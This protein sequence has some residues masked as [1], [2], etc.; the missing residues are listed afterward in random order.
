MTRGLAGIVIIS[1]LAVVILG[2]I[3]LHA[4]SPL[5]Y[6]PS[7][8][9]STPAHTNPAGLEKIGNNQAERL[10]PL[11]SDLLDSPGTVMVN[12]RYG[13]LD[14]AQRDLEEFAETARSFDTLVVNLEMSDSEIEE[15]RRMNRK[16]L[17]IMTELLNSTSRMNELST[18]EVR[19]RDSND[20]QALTSIT[21]EGE[22]LRN[23]VRDL[24]TEYES[25]REPMTR[26][27]EDLEL[28]ISEYQESHQ[29]FEEIVSNIDAE[30]DTR[31]REL[32]TIAIPVPDPFHITMLVSPSVVRYYDTLVISGFLSGPDTLESEIE[33][34]VDSQRVTSVVTDPSGAF[35]YRMRIESVST[36]GHTVFS[37]FKGITFSDIHSFTVETLPTTLTLAA[38]SPVK[39]G[40]S[41]SGS[42][43]A[44]DRPVSGAGV[45]IL[46]DG[47]VSRKIVTGNGGN[48]QT[49][50]PL[51]EGDHD[52]RA[53]FTPLTLPLDPSES[54]SRHVVVTPGDVPMT[55]PPLYSLL[56]GAIAIVVS[57][58]G[59]Y[60]YLK[61]RPGSLYPHP[62]TEYHPVNGQVS[63]PPE[64]LLPTTE[65]Q[66]PPLELRAGQALERYLQEDNARDAAR[67]LFLFLRAEIAARLGLR[68]EGS[69]TAREMVSSSMGR[70][71]FSPLRTFTQI[72]EKV[73]YDREIAGQ[74]EKDRMESA[75]SATAGDLEGD[76]H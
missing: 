69:I 8:D 13:D 29:I 46:L 45:D 54:E 74:D 70:A 9:G 11:M 63:P 75:F 19:F 3:A 18:L 53:V 36:G 43:M 57:S 30:Q 44:P 35:S 26:T 15:F 22:S 42:L 58:G 40:Y 47:R 1:A 5:L 39:E 12:I 51:P 67:L 21:Y 34:F 27:G 52:I 33:I 41:I 23:K 50:L 37:T 6:T 16:N 65:P 62:F 48:Y 31:T 76:E 61:R 56:F 14:L 68:H 71:F 73:R 64:D 55:V 66:K 2:L 4:T 38:P 59:A 32:Q 20:S 17:D 28:N 60:Y 25:Q 49:V 10:L 24:L 72:Y 7:F